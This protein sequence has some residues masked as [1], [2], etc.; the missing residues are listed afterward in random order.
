MNESGLALSRQGVAGS[1]TLLV[2]CDDLNLP[3][4]KLRLRAGGGGGGHKGLE[5]IIARLGTKDFARLRLGVGVPPPG[6]DWVEFVL[7]DFLAEER[8]VAERMVEEAVEAIDLA[9]RR[10]FDEAAQRCNSPESRWFQENLIQS[11]EHRAVMGDFA[12]DIG[13]FI[14]LFYQ[15]SK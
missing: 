3:L 12:I 1:G 13:V 11:P 6:V 9:V 5:S 4:G 15:I 2:V 8:G 14:W 7:S 10:G